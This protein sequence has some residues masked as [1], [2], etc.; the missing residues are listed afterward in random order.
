MNVPVTLSKTSQVRN[1]I[2]QI[3]G[4]KPIGEIITQVKKEVDCSD[5]LIRDVYKELNPPVEEQPKIE[6]I[7]QS[8]IEPVYRISNSGIALDNRL[9]PDNL[10]QII[11]STKDLIRLIGNKETLIELIKEL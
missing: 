9:K 4:T 10:L 1:I 6:T 7:G 8:R 5:R 2:S 3:G 11:R